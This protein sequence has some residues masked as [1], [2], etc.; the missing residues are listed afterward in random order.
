[1]KIKL[2]LLLLLF[3]QI[4]CDLKQNE[5]IP[6]NNS[7]RPLSVFGD[8][9]YSKKDFINLGNINSDDNHEIWIDMN[10]GSDH[11]ISVHLLNDEIILS[12]RNL[13]SFYYEL[14]DGKLEIRR[15]TNLG[16]QLNFIPS[17]SSLEKRNILQTGVA[18]L[19][20]SSVFDF[21]GK[22]YFLV[23]SSDMGD[24]GGAL[25]E[26]QRDK[27]KFNF[28]KV[29]DLDSAPETMMIL[30]DKLLVVCYQKFTLIEN[31]KPENIIENALWASLYPNS[32]VA[33]NEN[34]IYI[35]MRG[36]YSKLSLKTKQIEYFKY[37]KLEKYIDPFTGGF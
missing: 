4:S 5:R 22:I 24:S 8:T 29:L 21:K 14:D 25:V 17:D 35:G 1:M 18:G 26:I 13:D 19:A 34:E 10:H 27:E 20:I 2:F 33:K 36:G 9:T 6:I 12:R 37:K 16:G 30:D 15:N 32:I 7:I 23:G 3:S 31:F 11:E 28:K